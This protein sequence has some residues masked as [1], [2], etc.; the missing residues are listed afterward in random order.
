[1]VDWIQNRIEVLNTIKNR[2]SNNDDVTIIN[3]KSKTYEELLDYVNSNGLESIIEHIPMNSEKLID[4]KINSKSKEEKALIRARLQAYDE[5]FE[6][7]QNKRDV[8]Y[9]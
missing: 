4:K 5:C 7:V 6:Y 3:T 9:V 8:W 1:M 2:Y